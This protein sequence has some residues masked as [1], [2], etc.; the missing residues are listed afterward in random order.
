MNS[1]NI[2]YNKETIKKLGH[3][4]F[5]LYM[6]CKVQIER[7]EKILEQLEIHTV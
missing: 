1:N 7:I 3:E 2:I 6:N 5:E 4:F